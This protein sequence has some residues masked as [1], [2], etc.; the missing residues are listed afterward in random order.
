M[1]IKDYL[2]LQAREIDRHKWLESEKAGKDLGSEA[3]IDWILKYAD[4]F[5]DHVVGSNDQS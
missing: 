1:D 2:N 5:C 3:A 4:K